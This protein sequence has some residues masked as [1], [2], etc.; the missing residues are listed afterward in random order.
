MGRIKTFEVINYET[1]KYITNY[2]YEI[3][4]KSTNTEHVMGAKSRKC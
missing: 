1:L 4:L 3:Y 2:G